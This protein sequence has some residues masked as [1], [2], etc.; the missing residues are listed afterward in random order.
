MFTSLSRHLG[1]SWDT[2]NAVISG[3]LSVRLLESNKGKQ[4]TFQ[5]LLSNNCWLTLN[6]AT[7]EHVVT[8]RALFLLKADIEDVLR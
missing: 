6:P 3:T 7:G 8:R 4:N 1:H 2:N 5:N